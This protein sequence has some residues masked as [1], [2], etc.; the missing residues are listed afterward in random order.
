VGYQF[1]YLL[2]V[3]IIPMYLLPGH[4]LYLRK[5]VEMP[6][7]DTGGHACSGVG[8]AGWHEEDTTY[9]CEQ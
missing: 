8:Y 5:H 4:V 1:V 9:S 2:R 6:V 7:V 3:P